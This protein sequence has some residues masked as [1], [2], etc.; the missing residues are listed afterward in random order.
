MFVRR[1]NLNFAFI[2]LAY[3]RIICGTKLCV[4]L[5]TLWYT[6]ICNFFIHGVYSYLERAVSSLAHH[7]AQPQTVFYPFNLF[8][9]FL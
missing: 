9:T 4:P 2:S 3:R 1:F 6:A 8:I 7:L 5:L